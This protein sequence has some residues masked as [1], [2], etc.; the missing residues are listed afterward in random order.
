[1]METLIYMES[2]SKVFCLDLRILDLFD[3]LH[4]F[5]NFLYI[6]YMSSIDTTSGTTVPPNTPTSVETIT[7]VPTSVETSNQVPTSV[8]PSVETYVGIGSIIGKGTYKTV[9]S[10]KKSRK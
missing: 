1:M 2:C 9:Y 5:K 8:V 10:C 4:L 7:Q 6:I 3:L